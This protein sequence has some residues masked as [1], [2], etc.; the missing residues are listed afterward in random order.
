[1]ATPHPFGA[2]TIQRKRCGR[3]RIVRRPP[4]ANGI[5]IAVIAMP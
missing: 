1:L 4:A 3:N 2:R 5:P